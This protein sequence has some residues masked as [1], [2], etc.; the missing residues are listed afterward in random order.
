MLLGVALASSGCGITTTASNAATQLTAA[1]NDAAIRL[2]AQTANVTTVLDKLEADI[3]GIDGELASVIRNELTDLT[4]RAV[5]AVGEEFRCNVD[6]VGQRVS[7]GLQEL[8]DRVQGRETPLRPTF[9]DVTPKS[10]D[11]TLEPERRN[12][13]SISGFNFDT[14]SPK[15]R[16]F[17]MIEG[18]A[19]E[20]TQH[21]SRQTHYH[22]M[23]DLGGSS[24]AEGIQV[25]E[26]TT[27]IIV[28]WGDNEITQIPVIQRPPL[29]SCV[30]SEFTHAPGTF[31]Y[32]PP[33]TGRGDREFFGKVDVTVQVSLEVY[34]DHVDTR[35]R[36]HA[37]QYDDDHSTASGEVVYPVWTAP[38]GQRILGVKGPLVDTEV[39]Y[40]DNDW[41]DDT[42][43]ATGIVASYVIRA[44]GP[45]E[46]AG[47]WAQVS[48][49]YNPLR[50]E[51]ISTE[52]CQ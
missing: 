31:T 32:M 17:Q 34:Q 49:T 37:E 8:L 28:R 20:V 27:S 46:D 39:K 45:R 36:M 44:E 23:L 29:P 42:F 22:M 48:A 40:R 47:T 25:N 30:R 51:M 13:V 6:F 10:I 5:A 16:V 1:I 33:F 2:Q 38:T 3:A 11:L 50:I 41:E 12:T 14:E 18:N 26:K 52:N 15:V 19:L 4:T 35:V 7:D 43:G 24:P 9:C 21:M